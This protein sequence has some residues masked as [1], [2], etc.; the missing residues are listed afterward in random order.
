MKKTTFT[1]SFSQVLNL[2]NGS[3]KR[4]TKL[5]ILPCMLFVF[6][7]QNANAQCTAPVG[8]TAT[9]VDVNS[10][11]LQWSSTNLPA[12]NHQWII[13]VGGVAMT[14]GANN[15]PEAGQAIITATLNRTG[16]ATITSSNPQVSATVVGGTVTAV[17]NGLP[18]GTDLEFFVSE[19]CTGMAPPDNVSA[20]AGPGAF[21]TFDSPIVVN[22]TITAPTCPFG[23]ANYA[24]NGSFTVNVANG[25]CVGTYTVSATPVVGSGPAASTPPATAVTSYIGFPAGNFLFNNAGAGSYTVTILETGACILEVDPTVINV[26]VPD[27]VD[28]TPPTM[29]ITDLIGN[30]ITDSDFGPANANFGDIMLPEGACSRQDQFYVSMV[31]DCDG[32]LTGAGL[33][34]ATAVT[35]PA[36][37]N[38]NTQVS[39]IDDGFGQYLLDVQW[40][41]GETVI[42]VVGEDLSGNEATAT[43]TANVI[44]NINPSVTILGN[45]S[46]VIPQCADEA[47]VIYSVNIADVCDQSINFGN[48]VFNSGS[49]S[50]IINF[51]GTTY[52]EFLVTFPNVGNYL[53]SASYTDFYG[54]VGFFDIVVNVSKATNDAPILVISGNGGQFT[55]P[56]CEETTPIIFSGTIIDCNITAGTAPAEVINNLS[57]STFPA[58]LNFTYVDTNDGFAY[59]ELTGDLAP[60]SYLIFINYDNGDFS[61]TVDHLIDVFQQPA[62][63]VNLGCVGD[64][65]VSL[66][67]DCEVVITPSMLLN[68]TFGCLTA[69]D[70][71]VEIDGSTNTTISSCGTFTYMIRL[72]PGVV[73]NF[74][75]CWG[76]I[77][78]EDKRTLF[79]SCGTT[80]LE[81]WE[82]LEIG[83]LGEVSEA[84]DG[85]QDVNNVLI[86]EEIRNADCNNPAES[87]FTTVIERTFRLTD[88]FGN[89]SECTD[90]INVLR[91]SQNMSDY[92]MPAD[93]ELDCNATAAD[94]HPTN[95]GYPVYTSGGANIELD[96]TNASLICNLLIKYDDMELTGGCGGTRKFMRL[97]TITEWYC[98]T[99]VPKIV[100]SQ[101]ITLKDSQAPT[102]T[103][104]PAVETVWTNAYTCSRDLFIARPVVSDN[105]SDASDII[106]SLEFNGNPFIADFQGGLVTG[107]QPG[108]NILTFRAYDECGNS[109]SC[110]REII[111]VDDVP[112]IA[113]CQSNTTTSLGGDGTSRVYVESFNDGSFDN[114]GIESIQV[115]R[116]NP[117]ACDPVPVFRDYVEVCCTD[118]TGPEIPRVMVIMRVTDT[119]GNTNECMVE[120]EVQDKLPAVL[121]CPPNITVQCGFDLDDLSIFGK[122]VIKDPTEPIS[123]GRDPIIVDGTNW[124]LDGYA[125]DNCDLTVGLVEEIDINTCGVGTITRT[126][127]AVGAGNNVQRVCTQVITVEYNFDAFDEAVIFPCDFTTADLCV[128]D[129]ATELRPDVLAQF[130]G[131]PN[132]ACDRVNPALWFYDRPQ[133]GDD[134]CTQLGITYKDHVFEIQDSAC[135]KILREWKVI[136][137]CMMEAFP[138][139]PL[140]DAITTHT[141]VIKI[142]NTV[143]PE[144]TCPDDITV[145]SFQEVCSTGEFLTRTATATDD[146]TGEEDLFWNWQYYQNVGDATTFIT[147]TATP[148]AVG[149]GPSVSRNFPVGT[150]VIRFVVEDICGNTSACT[151]AVTVEDCKKPTP[152][153]HDIE[154]TLMPNTNPED[155]M[156][157]VN[158]RLFNAGSTDNCT[159]AGDLIFRIEYP[160]TGDGTTPPPAQDSVIVFTCDDLGLQNVRLWVGDEDGNWDFCTATIVIANNMGLPCPG[161]VT[162]GIVAGLIYTE[163]ESA[164]ESVQVVADNGNM[165]SNMTNVEGIFQLGNVPMG[166]T[167]NIIPERNDALRNGVNTMDIILIQRHILG[168]QRL[169]SPFKIIAADVN[170]TNSITG[171]DLVEIRRV[172]LDNSATFTNNKSWRFVD[173]SYTF[174]DTENPLGEN[175][176]E[177]SRV[178]NYNGMQ[179][180]VKFIGVKVGDVNQDSKANSASLLGTSSRN[181]NALTFEL[182]D[183]DLKAGNEYAVNFK[184]SDFNQIV[185]YQFTL[186]FQ[187]NA[188]TLT[189]IESG[190]LNVTEGNFGMANMHEGL[191]TTSWN[192]IKGV[193]VSAEDDLFTVTFRALQDGKLSEMLTVN[194]SITN[195]EAYEEGGDEYLNVA[196]NF[197][198]REGVISSN[199]FELY[200]N[201]P[202]PFNGET[203][204]GFNLPESGRAT[205][206]VYDVT[207]RMLRMIENDFTKGYNEVR[208]NR[209]DIG[210]TG[211]LYYE[212]RTPY[213][214][215]TK[216]MFLI[217]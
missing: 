172:I 43:L 112:P 81:C 51:T 56:A 28:N 183:M 189:N 194:S 88:I 54:N 46:V 68:G 84:C 124:G 191:I 117:S 202:N 52:R 196:L 137:W 98:G 110:T 25:T 27:G 26:V 152:V 53:L 148:T 34:T 159:A 211:I 15:C 185:G 24:P 134:V 95:T 217:D 57:G 87:N 195:A 116:M 133:F 89:V 72:A 216:K 177:T 122:V 132:P 69:D 107:F 161:G 76:D 109:S 74:N 160:I 97:W 176:R 20:C 79:L 82:A 102:I 11:T 14:L 104:V 178:V 35:T 180:A 113:N 47:S 200:Q 85:C 73:A 41:I 118:V 92:Q 182:N 207:G 197:N 199:E 209:T 3:F 121:F 115:R 49:A 168:I 32:F 186:G 96:P 210:G 149:S 143:A 70:F 175:F 208:I 42:T 83:F 215:A 106:V 44:D 162:G 93:V 193:S 173:E 165:A 94:I 153:C 156:V 157:P 146:C 31:D 123:E 37:V 127:T 174:N 50:D 138:G 33:V 78:V 169:D 213:A 114:C 22:T 8:L 108:S 5:L 45:T 184:S 181:N 171:Q 145:C 201:R 187:P 58:G 111:V 214:T 205:I 10:A 71:I 86:L 12:S 204:I 164:V 144:I 126:F 147:A 120:L 105:C 167:F 188:I 139:L 90:V 4:F 48:L 119:S 166:S 36:T 13:S 198:T 39:V 170:K 91:P 179:P 151:S 40:S 38:P 101:L 19:Q 142:M 128:T 21:T 150:H 131:S 155:Q 75:P 206:T 59:F 7:L 6:G 140:E 23:S 190:A 163:T 1:E 61:V 16:P 18:P 2:T 203:M 129:P 192:D 158:A 80:E 125:Y 64:I 77:T 136:D 9:D 30:T 55:V 154:T 100:D 67:D 135:Y 66:N 60:G 29:T 103:C 99:L 141:Q 65:N 130:N 212:L 62:T 17:V 63:P